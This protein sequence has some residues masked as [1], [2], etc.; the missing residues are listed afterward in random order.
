MLRKLISGGQTGIDRGALDAA[1]SRA[2]PCGGWCPRGRRAEDGPIPAPHPPERCR[3]GRH[4]DPGA[5]AAFGGNEGDGKTR[6]ENGKA[7]SDARSGRRFRRPG[8]GPHLCVDRNGTD[9]GTERR[10]TPRKFA[11]RNVG[12]RRRLAGG[13]SRSRQ[14]VVTILS[15]MPGSSRSLRDMPFRT[16]N[17]STLKSA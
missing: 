7:F 16:S 4:P 17:R 6:P 8:G 10:G 1:L 3:G 2:F 13:G 11:S 12:C 14:F 5:W 9:R 15:F